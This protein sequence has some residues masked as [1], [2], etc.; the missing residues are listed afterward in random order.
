M[1]AS[2]HF[3]YRNSAVIQIKCDKNKIATHYIPINNYFWCIFD[4]SNL[5]KNILRK[6]LFPKFINAFIK[7]CLLLLAY[8]RVKNRASSLHPISLT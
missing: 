5:L 6:N 8:Q 3:Q 2:L 4:N 1:N 7:M